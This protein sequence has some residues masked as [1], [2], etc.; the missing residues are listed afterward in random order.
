M[1]KGTIWLQTTW[2]AHIAVPFLK[3]VNKNSLFDQLLGDF[4]LKLVNPYIFKSMMLKNG[5]DMNCPVLSIII[6]IQ[7]RI[8]F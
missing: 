7:I 2:N 3:I 6:K 8:I 5:F 1:F 4:H